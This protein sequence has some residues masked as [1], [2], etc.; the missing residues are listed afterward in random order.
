M[1]CCCMSA[2]RDAVGAV[3]AV[4]EDD[5]RAELEGLGRLA[6]RGVELV[7]RLDDRAVEVRARILGLERRE[8]R[9][10]RLRA[11][12][13]VGEGDDGV[14]VGA[15]VERVDADLLLLLDAIGERAHGLDERL[16]RPALAH[17]AAHVDEEER[18]VH[19]RDLGVQDRLL[20]LELRDEL[21]VLVDPEAVRRQPSER[22]APVVLHLE[23]DGDVARLLLGRLDGGQLQSGAAG[24]EQNKER[25]THSVGRVFH[26]G[27]V[28]R[29]APGPR[30]TAGRRR[31]GRSTRRS[32]GSVRTR[33][34]TRRTS[35]RS[36][37]RATRAPFAS[38]DRRPSMEGSAPTATRG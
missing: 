22:L 15:A 20:A 24:P 21:V 28:P 2:R 26:S 5:E 23:V 38:C 13:L 27:S 18:V 4:R 1:M 14:K 11:P 35:A 30:V 19:G 33:S 9:D 8:L 17:A 10:A 7:E 16:A 34:L 31:I 37:C 3:G 25:S 12:R 32:S 36:R 6:E 29:S